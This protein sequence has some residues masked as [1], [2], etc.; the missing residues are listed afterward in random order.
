MMNWS[1]VFL[2][3]LREICFFF[4]Q[5]FVVFEIGSNPKAE[6][7]I[8]LGEVGHPSQTDWSVRNTFYRLLSFYRPN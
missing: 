3:I 4:S 5:D 2:Y 8:T 1:Q 6:I 7:Q